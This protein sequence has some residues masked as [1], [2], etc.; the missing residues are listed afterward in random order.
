MSGTKRIAYTNINK[1]WFR[2]AR[3]CRFAYIKPNNEF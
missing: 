3:H 1:F 2:F